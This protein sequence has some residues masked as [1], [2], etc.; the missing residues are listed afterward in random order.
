M[1]INTFGPIFFDPIIEPT[2]LIIATNTD[3]RL[4]CGVFSYDYGDYL[5]QLN[6]NKNDFDKNS[7]RK[8][9]TKEN[10]RLKS[11]KFNAGNFKYPHFGYEAFEIKRPKTAVKNY[12][13]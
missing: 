5:H 3:N 13:C 1:F 9:E 12:Y 7:K 10:P 6:E 8:F 11:I 4:D 2:K